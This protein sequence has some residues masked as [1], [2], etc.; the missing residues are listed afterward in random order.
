MGKAICNECVNL[1]KYSYVSLGN[2]V[3]HR[4]NC[5]L[6]ATE[7]AERCSHFKQ[8]KVEDKELQSK[9][10]EALKEK[11]KNIKKCK[12]CNNPLTEEEIKDGDLDGLC[13]GCYSK[14]M[15]EHAM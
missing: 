12:E 1:L 13:Y 2:G 9:G 7:R 8:K 5:V 14:Y 11:G 4:E 10:Q 15:D 6:G 3:V